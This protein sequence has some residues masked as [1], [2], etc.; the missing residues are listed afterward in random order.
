MI[1]KCDI[2]ENN[3]KLDNIR[4]LVLM[5]STFTYLLFGAAIFDYL[6]SE[7]EIME[8]KTLLK[9]ENEFLIKYNITLEEFEEF[10]L[11]V[12][13]FKPYRYGR[14]W[15]F[16]GALYFSTTV[17]TSIGYGHVTPRTQFGKV[18]CILFA[19]TG[20]PM[21]L[22]ML[23]CV[24]ERINTLIMKCIRYA[25]NYISVHFRKDKKNC[26]IHKNV[27]IKKNSI[28][29]KII[30]IIS[31]SCCLLLITLG[32]FAFSYFEDWSYIDSCYFCLITLTTIGFGDF[33]VRYK[34]NNLK[35][36][37]GYY[38]FNLIFIFIGLSIVSAT[39][40]L[41]VLRFMTVNSYEEKLLEIEKKNN[42]MCRKKSS[43]RGRINSFFINILRMNMK[44][45]NNNIRK[46]KSQTQKSPSIFGE[47][48]FSFES[49][50]SNLNS[51]MD[52]NEKFSFHNLNSKFNSSSNTYIAN[53]NTSN[54]H[55]PLHQKCFSNER[56][57][58]KFNIKPTKLK[59]KRIYYVKHKNKFKIQNV[60]DF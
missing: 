29:N 60:Q 22:V 1:H 5:T 57:H 3:M 28:N 9:E 58:F 45:A 51:C 46:Y 32:G 7:N 39:M 36:S 12:I 31:L 38:S 10:R 55:T 19:I 34:D 56:K 17:L 24:G 37:L 33:V 15:K 59:H 27:E 4:T 14:Q 25:N 40:N 18:F 50:S 16:Y 53:F 6:E 47:S 11:N 43:M 54:V 52:F 13:K 35:S 48:N 42:A 20:I 49:K 8:T 21:G 2:F 30:T 44:S 23:Q 41:L 26:I